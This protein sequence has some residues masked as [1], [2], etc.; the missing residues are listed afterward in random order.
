MVYSSKGMV[1][2]TQPLAS[3]A[4]QRILRGGGNAADA[5]VAVSAALNMTEPCST[6]IGGDT[7]FLY[8]DAKTG[9]VHALN[10]SGRSAKQSTLEQVQE[11]LSQSGSPPAKVPQTNALAVTVPGAPAGW[12]DTVEKFGSGK[13]TMAEILAPAIE[14]GEEGFPVSDLASHRWQA[15]EADLKAASPNGNEMLKRNKSGSYHAPRPGEIMHNRNLANTFRALAAE[16]KKGF[17]EGRIAQSIVDVVRNGGGLLGLSDLQEHMEIGS[18]KTQAISL[19]YNGGDTQDRGPVELWEHP[20]NGQGIVALMALGIF[21]ILQDQKKIP[22]FTAADQNTVPYLHALI[23]CLKIAFSDGCWWIT[24]PDQ[25]PV[26]PSELL[27]TAYLTERARLFDPERAKDHSYGKPGPSP[28][29][30]HNDTVY[31]AVVDKDGNGMSFINSNYEG[32]G[33]HIVPEGCGF[34]LQNRASN[35]NLSPPDHPNIYSGGKRPY[36]TIIPGMT[37]FGVGA[38][39]TLHS[40][41]GVM[42]GFM[43]PQGHIQVLFNQV[44][45]GMNPQ[46]ALDAPRICIVAEDSDRVQSRDVCVEEGMDEDVI[47]GL[48]RMGHPTKVLKGWSRSMFGRGQVITRHVDEGTGKVVFAGGSDLR[49][50]G[51]AIPA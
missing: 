44:L 42:G 23:E 26:S 17:Y 34:T 47:R 36:H 25:S 11:R 21:Q 2:S 43:Q 27:S 22:A 8:F 33:S 51:A 20:P 41:Y 39:R 24:D 29:H 16:G 50:D 28:A 45:F 38:E 30:N 48:E 7:F 6:G 18:E 49:G 1:A 35:F 37:T 15:S 3:E 31:F 9:Q 19:K 10:G 4:G 14:L 32:F 12:V 13:L 46:E 40:V 5:A